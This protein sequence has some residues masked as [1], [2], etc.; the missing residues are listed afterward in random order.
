[1]ATSHACIAASFKTI[2]FPT[3]FSSCSEAALP[4]LLSFARC[5]D[6]TVIA[7]HAVP[8]EPLAG[9]A[10]VPPMVEFDLEWRNALQAIR[11]YEQTH[12]FTGLRHEFILERGIL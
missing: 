2:L 10:S 6:S 9:L 3:D 12:P 8:Y 7:A 11:T 1:M 4:Y 5:F